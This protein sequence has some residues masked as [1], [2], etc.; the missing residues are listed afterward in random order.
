MRNKK[1]EVSPEIYRVK[2]RLDTV[3]DIA[4]FVLAV[5]KIKENVY[6]TNGGRL[7]IDGK[8]FLGLSHAREFDTLYCEC[9]KD[10]YHAIYP[11]LASE[12]C[13]NVSHK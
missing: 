6:I 9:D 13:E 8:S 4:N 11:F 5:S 1:I 10:I 3:T 12:V 7:C 2:I